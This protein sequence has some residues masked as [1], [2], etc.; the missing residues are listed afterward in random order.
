M[1]DWKIYYEVVDCIDFNVVCFLNYGENFE[2][3][4]GGRRDKVKVLISFD[5]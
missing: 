1:E 5:N 3:G 2:F 4:D